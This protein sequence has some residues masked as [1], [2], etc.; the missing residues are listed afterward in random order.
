MPDANTAL[1]LL[2]L[3]VLLFGAPRYFRA[4]QAE[5][6][7]AEK[8]RVIDTHVQTIEADR[9]RI[10]GLVSDLKGCQQRAVDIEERN[11]KLADAAAH[12]QGKYEEA[13]RYTAREA[14]KTLE[15]LLVT[16]GEEAERRHAEM[17]ELLRATNHLLEKQS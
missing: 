3:V 7:E 16:Q 9:A 14:L 11:R 6:R 1:N 4:S 13:Q 2:M 12:L 17:V 5:A 10:D 8:D 15:R